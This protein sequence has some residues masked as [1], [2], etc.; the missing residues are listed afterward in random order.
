MKITK[1]INWK[2]YPK[3]IDEIYNRLTMKKLVALFD[4]YKNAE[5]DLFLEL[6]PCVCDEADLAEKIW[7]SHKIDIDVNKWFDELGTQKS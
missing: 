2:D 1:E 7:E 5:S 4:D 6:F 3:F